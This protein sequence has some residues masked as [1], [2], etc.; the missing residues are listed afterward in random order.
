MA[1]SQIVD[2]HRGTPTHTPGLIYML[3][4]GPLLLLLGGAQRT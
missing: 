2:A 1:T 3:A 4:L